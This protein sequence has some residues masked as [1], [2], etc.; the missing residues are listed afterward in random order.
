VGLLPG[1]GGTQRL[2][3]MHRRWKQSLPTLLEGKTVAARRGAQ[4][5][6]GGCWW[7]AAADLIRRRMR[8]WILDKPDP[9]RAW[10]QTG[11]TALPVVC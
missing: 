4:A 9:V 11:L 10:G 6:H 3:R 7:S 1:S 8:R 2:P 5:W